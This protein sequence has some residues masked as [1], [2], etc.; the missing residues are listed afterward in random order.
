MA[1]AQ[2]V[3][4]P[5]EALQ[6]AEPPGAVTIEGAGGELLVAQAR[7]AG[8]DYVFSNPRFFEVGFFDALLDK[9]GMQLIMG[10]H[11]GIVVSMA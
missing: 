7:A 3:L 4:E 9:S 10:L 2:A 5:L 6:R 1:G 11:E 8:I